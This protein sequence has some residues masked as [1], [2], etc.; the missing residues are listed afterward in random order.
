MAKAPNDETAKSDTSAQGQLQEQ[1]RPFCEA[2]NKF[3]QQLRETH[4]KQCRTAADTQWDFLGRARESHSA[5]LNAQGDQRASA[6]K[7]V[8]D[9]QNQYVEALQDVGKNSSR[10][11]T[12]VYRAY[13]QDVQAAW[14]QTDVSTLSRPAL[15]AISHSTQLAAYYAYVLGAAA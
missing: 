11:A 9:L 2:F 13:L 12:G 10:D 5:F 1:V 8:Q 3:V 7:C 15:A 6:W 14:A 4:A